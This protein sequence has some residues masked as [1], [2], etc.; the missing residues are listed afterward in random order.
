MQL[1]SVRQAAEDG[2]IGL[3][4]VKIKIDRDPEHVGEGFPYLGSTSDTPKSQVTSLSVNQPK[5]I[6]SDSDGSLQGQDVFFGFVRD[7]AVRSRLSIVSH[8]SI[9]F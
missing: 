4:G 1:R 7:S 3:K 8:S 9:I 2:G 5:Q 6:I